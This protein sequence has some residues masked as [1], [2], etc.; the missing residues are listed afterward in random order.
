[1]FS[2]VIFFMV[3]KQ[4]FFNIKIY[5]NL[6]SVYKSA[7]VFW[8]KNLGWKVDLYTGKYGIPKTQNVS[9]L[10]FMKERRINEILIV[11]V[12]QEKVLAIIKSLENKTTGPA[13]YS[14]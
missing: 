3:L 8:P 4:K 11:H 13:K 5:F 12:S 6:Y 10:K 1:M 7:T 2:D 14:N 9:P